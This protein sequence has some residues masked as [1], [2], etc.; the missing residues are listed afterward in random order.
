MRSSGSN[1]AASFSGSALAARLNA[2]F[3][4]VRKTGKLPAAVDRVSYEL[5][6]GRAEL[7]MHKHCIREGAKVLVVDDLLA[8]GGTA[9]A[10]AELVRRQGGYVTAFAFVIELDFLGGRERVLPVP[11][12]SLLRYPLGE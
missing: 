7:E 10:T 9:A 3:V 8:T 6:Y 2:S 5:E 4:P 11:V 1:R 12:V